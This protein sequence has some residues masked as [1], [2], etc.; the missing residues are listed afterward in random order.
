[1]TKVKHQCDTTRLE[2]VFRL[3]DSGTAENAKGT[4]HL[5]NSL[6]VSLKTEPA[7]TI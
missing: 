6:A 2:W 1:M 7:M 5:K 4:T 3:D